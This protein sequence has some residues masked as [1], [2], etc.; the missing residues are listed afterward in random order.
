MSSGDGGAARRAR[1]GSSTG[2]VGQHVASLVRACVAAGCE[3]LVCGPAA[4]DEHSA[5]PPAGAE[6]A[7]GRDPGQPRPAGLRRDPRRCAG[8]SPAATS[9]WCTRTGCAPRSS[10]RWPARPRRWWSPGT[11]PSW[12][13]ACAGSASALVE[14]IVARTAALTLGASEDL[15]ARAAALGARHARLG[16][17]AAPALAPPKRTRAAVRAEFRLGRRHPADPLGRPAA[18]AEALRPAGR[19][20]RPVA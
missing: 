2:G 14:R 3:V 5:S 7:A 15:V 13:G 12:P 6:F 20:G 8:R 18:P 11:T 9:T 1:A 4:T 16:A 19:R 17:V 10:P